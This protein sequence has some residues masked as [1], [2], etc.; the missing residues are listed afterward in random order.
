[1]SAD[2]RRLDHVAIAVRDTEAALRTFHERLALPIVHREELAEPHVR[3]TYLQAGNAYLQLVEPLEPD[4]EIARFLDEHGEGLHHLCFGVVDLDAAIGQLS[5][6]GH[7]AAPGNGRG[8]RSAFVPGP[9][10][11]GVRIECTEFHY[12]EDVQGSLGWLPGED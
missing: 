11:H 10:A 7:D 12:D 9:L 2:V 8:R 6:D 3:L 1:M 5:P 4:G